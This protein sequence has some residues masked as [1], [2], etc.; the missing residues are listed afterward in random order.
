[1]KTHEEI[2]ISDSCRTKELITT[3]KFNSHLLLG[4]ENFIQT[5]KDTK[6]L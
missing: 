2:Y 3:C 1:M 5:A 6:I 4:L